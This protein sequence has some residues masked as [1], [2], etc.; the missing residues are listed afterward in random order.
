MP[1]ATALPG[2]GW[3][4]VARE[5][6]WM[7]SSPVADG[8]GRLALD[9]AP[10]PEPPERV[11]PRALRAWQ[12]S[13]AIAAMTTLVV[14]LAVAAVAWRLGLSWPLACLP[15]LLA[16]VAVPFWVWF[17]PRVRWRR[18]RYAVSDRDIELQQGVL[19]VTRTLIPMSRVQHVDTRPGPILR[20]YGLAS[21]AIATAAGTKEIPALAVEVADALRD[22]IAALAGVAEDV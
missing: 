12:V 4:Y 17:I 2:A 1:E 13:G 6:R 22:R 9:L 20:H 14:A 7:S 3:I 15:P 10:R 8:D 18:W 16:I 21:V 19:I 5:E 11:D